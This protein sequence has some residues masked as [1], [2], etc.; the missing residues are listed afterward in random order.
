MSAMNAAASQPPAQ[1]EAT[2]AR[3]IASNHLL[4]RFALGG[5]GGFVTVAATVSP[6]R[7]FI[8]AW[9]MKVSPASLPGPFF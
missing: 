7:F 5:T 9:P 2:S 1:G 8:S 4:W 3:R 6:L